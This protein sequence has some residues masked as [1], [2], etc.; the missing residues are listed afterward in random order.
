MTGSVQPIFKRG[1]KFGNIPWPQVESWLA[2]T[3]WL[4]T[5]NRKWV[6]MIF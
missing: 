3:V 5:A 1:N 2:V 4:S 6:L